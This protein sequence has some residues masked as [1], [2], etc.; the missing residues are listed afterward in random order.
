MGIT[1]QKPVSS[2][3]CK[4]VTSLELLK[5]PGAA[6]PAA[7]ALAGFCVSQAFSWCPHLLAWQ[8]TNPRS[9]RREA[10][11]LRCHRQAPEAAEHP[12]TPA[13]SRRDHGAS[14]CHLSRTCR[15]SHTSVPPW[16][17]P[18]CFLSSCILYLCQPHSCPGHKRSLQ[19]R[20]TEV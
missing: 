10:A 19:L 13:G 7:P 5:A 15:L 6:L 14:T 9:P 3:S 20:F 8:G 17:Q 1:Q 16:G 4:T 12:R 18:C 11:V 2:L